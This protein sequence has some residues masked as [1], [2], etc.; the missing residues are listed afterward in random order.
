MN[1][2]DLGLNLSTE[3]TRKREFL[4][5]MQTVVS[6]ADLA[7]LIALYASE[8][9]KGRPPFAAESMLRAHF[10]RQCFTLGDPAMEE[11]LYNVPLFRKFANV[12]RDVRLS[13]EGTILRFGKT[14]SSR[15]LFER[16]GLAEHIVG[17]VND[18]L[19]AEALLLKAGT[20]VDATLI[21]APSS[22]KNAA[23]DRD[24][25][26][27][28][29]KDGKQWYFGLQAPIG[30]DADSGLA[31]KARRT[32]ANV[33]DVVELRYLGV[34]KHTAQPITLFAP[35]NIWMARRKLRVVAGQVRPKRALAG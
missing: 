16:H 33:D 22:T 25:E 24:P 35:T 23:G 32:A 17:T 1:Q 13:D 26:M 11:A 30:V 31:H 29:T 21:A 6:G 2:A 8:G 34:K 3:R 28:P 7:A 14:P 27:H 4:G 15:H 19:Q 9:K 18:L 5:V 10:M 12:G 20:L